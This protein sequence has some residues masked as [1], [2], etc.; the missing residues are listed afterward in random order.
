[1][2]DSK[3]FSLSNKERAALEH[4]LRQRKAD[5]LIVRR[6][7]ALLLLDKGWSASQVADALFLDVETIR[8]WR[9][10]FIN[11]GMDFLFLLPY[12]K[13][14]GHLDLDQERALRA[15]LVDHPLR[16]TNEIRRYIHNRF[17]QE[18]SRSGAIKLMGRFG[19][20]YKK[21][22][23][24]PLKAD[25]REQREFIIKYNRLCNQ[26]MADEAIVFGDAVHPEHQ[27]RPA[28]GWFLRDGKPAMV[29]TS[30][31]KRLNIHGCL[32][33]ETFQ[34]QFVETE[35]INADSTRQ[36]L[37]KLEVAYPFKAHNSCVS[38]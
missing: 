24:L 15:Y 23:V 17:G 20:V 36:L 25:E 19:F 12:S 2:T 14:Q 11:T 32:N 13:R 7:N 16:S 38:R 34:F 35:K 5:G 4:V 28:Y 3:S 6:A 27:S 8:K 37:Q 21:P 9:L 29:A 1:M 10:E 18:Y 26:L 31:R 22:K 30:G 33:L